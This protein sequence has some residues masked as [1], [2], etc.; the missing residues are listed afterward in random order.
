MYHS[1][2]LMP[3]QYFN[4]VLFTSLRW[5]FLY[6]TLPRSFWEC[7]WKSFLYGYFFTAKDVL[8]IFP[9]LWFNL[10]IF[11]KVI[12]QVGK[13]YWKDGNKNKQILHS[14]HFCRTKDCF[15]INLLSFVLCSCYVLIAFLLAYLLRVYCTWKARTLLSLK[16][17][18]FCKL[19]FRI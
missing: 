13:C 18:C 3:F 12:D 10:C 4:L 2:I 16:R 1:W 15:C 9:Q 11:A 7:L 17:K 6:F 14:S 5:I 8:H 19:E